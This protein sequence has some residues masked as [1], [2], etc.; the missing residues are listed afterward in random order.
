MSNSNEYKVGDVLLLGNNPE[1]IKDDNYYVV[2][3]SGS[4]M[5]TVREATL[6]DVYS[7][8]DF[9]YNNSID[10]VKED[11]NTEIIA[12]QVKNEILKDEAGLVF[13]TNMYIEGA[14]NT[15]EVI[16]TLEG[17]S[18]QEIDNMVEVSKVASIPKDKIDVSLNYTFNE[19]G[20]PTVNLSVSV[21][22]VEIQI[23]NK[24]SLSIT[25]TVSE[26]FLASIG[27]SIEKAENKGF[28][29]YAGVN[30]TNKFT[31]A[32]SIELKTDSGVIDLAQQVEDFLTGSSAADGVMY[33]WVNE[34]NDAKIMETTFDY[35]PILEEELFE[36]YIYIE[37]ISLRVKVDGVIS[38]GA[39][40]ALHASYSVTT[41]ANAGKTNGYI[42]NGEAYTNENGKTKTWSN[43][44]IRNSSFNFA[45]KGAVGIRAGLKLSVDISVLRM[46]DL[47]SIGISL[48]SGIY[49]EFTGFIQANVDIT[50]SKVKSNFTGGVNLEIGIYI[51][52]DFIWN[53]WPFG[54]DSTDDYKLFNKEIP[55]YKFSTLGKSLGF[56]NASKNSEEN[57]IIV[58]SN[59][60]NIFTDEPKIGIVSAIKYNEQTQKY[61]RIETRPDAYNIYFRTIEY[62]DD[63]TQ[64]IYCYTDENINKY[65]SIVRL[66]EKEGTIV[67]AD[68]A[69]DDYK[70]F[71]TIMSYTKDPITGEITNTVSQDVW[72]KYEKPVDDGVYDITFD[73]G[74]GSLALYPGQKQIQL[75][76]GHG[77]E[78]DF[79][80]IPESY[81]KDGITY[82]F[83][84]WSNG[85]NERMRFYN[86]DEIIKAI[87]RET[88]A[89]YTYTFTAT[90]GKFLNNSDTLTFEVEH[91]KAFGTVDT[92]TRLN[93]KFV[94]WTT[95]PLGDTPNVTIKDGFLYNANNE[96][97]YGNTTVFAIWQEVEADKYTLTF[98]AGDGWMVNENGTLSH[99]AT[100]SVKKGEDFWNIPIAMKSPNDAL[101]YYYVDET[102][103]L[104]P[105]FVP[106]ESKTY[107]ANY[108]KMNRSF[109]LF[110][111]D[112]TFIKKD[113][114]ITY[115]DDIIA[116]VT[117]DK[118]LSGNFNK[119]LTLPSA[120]VA[121]DGQTYTTNKYIIIVE[122]TKQVPYSMKSGA[123]NLKATYGWNYDTINVNFYGHNISAM[124]YTP[125][126]EID[127]GS[128][129]SYF[130]NGSGLDLKGISYIEATIVPYFEIP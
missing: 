97:I 90:N 88:V 49:F 57:P 12:Q 5:L 120:S 125:N 87:Y 91:E 65:T 109:D 34:I 106:T 1:D 32:F 123:N 53:C 33:D 35:L 67:I 26:E 18:Q 96:I 2:T 81:T 29:T 129:I 127:Y 39:E 66:G 119:D 40:A 68:E 23:G 112:S 128:I 124:L 62:W 19:Y 83:E 113:G 14:Y 21:K 8:L 47:Y 110:I 121:I 24:G 102:F 6:E 9:S 7:E 64:S 73:L 48:E 93:H 82:V 98:D 108:K 27:I 50:Y 20:D 117:E 114:A 74:E 10:F 43:S 42:E 51:E 85:F 118:W 69:P 86:G 99:K 37:L 52:L 72:F 84:K 75:S 36:K 13:L 100:Y 130:H 77:G 71:Y 38:V 15:K 76:V 80:H 101:D 95:D 103:G 89:K 31:M 25:F 63:K 70:F 105:G 94:G 58:S 115:S 111:S 126:S 4:S 78:I 56:T 116:D 59:E 107:K 60:F 61:E 92:P 28:Y 41:Y 30:I 79:P 22:G 122:N 11:A 16:Q 46:N 17:H 44:G 55:L 45:L 54:M 104:E 3:E